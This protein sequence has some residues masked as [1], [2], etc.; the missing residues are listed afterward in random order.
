MHKFAILT[1]LVVLAGCGLAENAAVPMHLGAQ[2]QGFTV[3][4]AEVTGK[5]VRF[6]DTRTGENWELSVTPDTRLLSHGSPAKL[7][8]FRAG[9]KV[10]VQ[11]QQ[12]LFLDMDNLW[13]GTAAQLTLL[14]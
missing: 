9:S 1:G 5:L 12:A 7:S 4:L 13:V 14:D 6:Q 8:Q 11:V 2:S 3:K 10:R